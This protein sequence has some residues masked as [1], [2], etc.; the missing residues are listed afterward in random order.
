[1]SQPES[2]GA[3]RADDPLARGWSDG[4]R[5]N[6]GMTEPDNPIVTAG[7]L[8]EASVGTSETLAS[9]SSDVS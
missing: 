5:H 1:M 3:L 9:V 8:P 4:V 7:H 2:D 6:L